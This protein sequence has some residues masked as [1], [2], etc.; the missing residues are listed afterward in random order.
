M[1]DYIT[2]LHHIVLQLRTVGQVV[3]ANRIVDRLVHGLSPAYD[4]LKRNL[5]TR[6]LDEE[7]CEE[8]LLQEETLRNAEK[9][10]TT[11]PSTTTPA[12][13]PPDRNIHS[14]A[15][16]TRRCRTCNRHGHIERD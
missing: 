2:R 14:D 9:P 13:S 11:V 12:T 5:R 3:D 4:D 16:D 7:E 1:R 8:I 6:R 10:I 15:S